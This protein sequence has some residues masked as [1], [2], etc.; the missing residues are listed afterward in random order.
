MGLDCRNTHT[1][2]KRGRTKRRMVERGRDPNKAMMINHEG[3]LHLRS[4]KHLSCL[5]SHVDYLLPNSVTIVKNLNARGRFETCWPSRSHK[6]KCHNRIVCS[7]LYWSPLLACWSLLPRRAPRFLYVQLKSIGPQDF[8]S[9]EPPF[10]TLDLVVTRILIT[11][12]F[13]AQPQRPK[14][15]KKNNNNKKWFNI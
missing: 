11:I 3:L 5:E 12:E 6:G 14:K 15:Q 8:L 1:H 4:G 10:I 2:K 13:A 9:Q 7:L